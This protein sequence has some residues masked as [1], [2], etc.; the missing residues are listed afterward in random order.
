MIVTKKMIKFSK[1]FSG[2]GLCLTHV[3][4]PCCETWLKFEIEAKL[5][6]A[7]VGLE[8]NH[9]WAPCCE[10]TK[11]WV[12]CCAK[13]GIL[14]VGLLGGSFTYVYTRDLKA[15]EYRANLSRI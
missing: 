2:R 1:Y 13:L 10:R 7:G 11:S 12:P 5:I 8:P 14:Q 9:V 3:G 6:I 4:A 15:V